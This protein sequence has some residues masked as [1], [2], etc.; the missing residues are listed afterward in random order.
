MTNCCCVCLILSVNWVLF[1]L[2]VKL[3]LQV[4]LD[5]LLVLFVSGGRS[6][7]SLQGTGSEV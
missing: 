4:E 3:S 1:L 5:V 2:I 6:V 7:C